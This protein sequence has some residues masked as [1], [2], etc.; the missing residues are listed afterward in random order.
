M[1][2]LLAILIFLATYTLNMV[3]ITVGYHRGLA[4]GAVDIAP[5]AR[6]L[7]VAAGPW[8]TGLDPKAWVVMHRMHHAYSDTPE[9]PHSPRNVGI[10]GIMREQLRS[11]ERTIRRL[12]RGSERTARFAVD[13]ESLPLNPLTRRGLW[14]VPYVVHAVVA[15]ALGLLSGSVL[16]GVAYYA[17]MMSHPIQGGLVNAFGH[18]VGGRNFATNDD[19]RNNHLVA[20]ITF[21]EGFQNNH[22]H[23]PASARFSF[24]RYELDLG[25]LVCRTLAAGKVLTIKREALLPRPT[26][27]VLA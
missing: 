6:R 7:L 1:M 2:V 25:Y 21:G 12:Q 17:G 9:D 11:Y 20:W 27:T 10:V 23:A 14:W 19:A 13:L 3:T 26:S 24:H 15:L 22:H 8:I 18:A 5:W 16:V 4:H